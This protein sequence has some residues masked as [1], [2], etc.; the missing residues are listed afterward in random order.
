MLEKD[1][2]KL[3]HKTGERYINGALN[4]AVEYYMEVK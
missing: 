1:V 4:K 3:L 2:N